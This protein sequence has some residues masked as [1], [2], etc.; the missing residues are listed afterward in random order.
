MTKNETSLIDRTKPELLA[1]AGSLEAFF[2]AMEKGADAV[3]AGLKE[4]SARAKAKNFTLDQME[5][6][7]AYAHA[8]DRKVYVTLNTLV[9]EN[10]L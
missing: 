10:E 9:K 8:R 4:F 1:P 6:M 3:Y 7:L 2:A 5:R